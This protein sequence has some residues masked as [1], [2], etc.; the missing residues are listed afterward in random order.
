M[1][2]ITDVTG[3]AGVFGTVGGVVGGVVGVADTGVLVVSVGQVVA[4][5]GPQLGPLQ[6]A[7]LVIVP[8]VCDAFTVTEKVRAYETPAATP[9]GIVQ[10]IV[11]PLST[12]AQAGGPPVHAGDPDTKVVP[13][14]GA[15]VTTTGSV[16][17]AVPTLATFNV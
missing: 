12:T 11:E 9:A 6:V 7:V 16:V 5:D 4:A 15:S 8:P 14:G 17:V 1:K 2:A 3:V 13:G 10:V